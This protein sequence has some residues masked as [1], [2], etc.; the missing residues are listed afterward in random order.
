MKYAGSLT[1]LAEQQTGRYYIGGSVVHDQVICYA[2]L[3]GNGSIGDPA[4]VNDY[5]EAVGVLLSQNLTY[6][7]SQGSGGVI[8]LVTKDPYQIIRGRVSGTTTAGGD[9]VNASTANGN[10]LT[11]ESASSG[12]T[13]ITDAGVGTSEFAGGYAIGLTGNNAG[14]VRVIDSHTDNTSTT[15][16]DPFD[17]AIATGDT[18]LRTFAPFLQGIE[19]VTA[20]T[21]FMGGGVAG[22]DLPDS[23][24]AV[25]HEVW[26]G[27]KQLESSPVSPNRSRNL[28]ARIDSTSNPSVEVMAS[29][30]DHAF[31]SVA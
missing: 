8:G 2:G 21:E 20:F 10:I 19:L 1:G 23:G 15:L 18:F 9:W 6:S 31:M 3:A 22:V 12:G 26:C 27:G 5:T 25:I 14:H 13:V 17:S 16:D 28:I 30:I 4:S 7:T 11:A 24:H 29:F